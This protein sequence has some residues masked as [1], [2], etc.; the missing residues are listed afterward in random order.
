LLNKADF[1]T[2]SHF[3]FEVATVL[4]KALICFRCT[5]ENFWCKKFKFWCSEGVGAQLWRAKGLFRWIFE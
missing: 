3:C 1:F 2:F 5:L 4:V